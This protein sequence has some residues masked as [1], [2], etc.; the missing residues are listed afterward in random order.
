MDWNATNLQ[1]QITLRHQRKPDNSDA[2]TVDNISDN[3]SL[4]PPA[5]STPFFFLPSL[6]AV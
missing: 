6:R 5:L 1:M 2:V 3:N 4:L